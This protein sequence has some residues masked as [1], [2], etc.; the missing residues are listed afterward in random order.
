MADEEECECPECPK[1]LPAYLATF[2]DLM[3]LLM[4]FFV[5]LLAFSEMDVQK[6]KQVAGSMRDAFGVQDKIKMK[7]I[8]KGTSIIAQ[9]FSPGRPQPTPLNEVRQS[10]TETMENTLDVLCNPGRS[11]QREEASEEQSSSTSDHSAEILEKLVAMTQADAVEVASMMKEDIQNGAVEVETRNRRIVIRVKEQGSFPSGSATLHDEFIPIMDKIRSALEQIDGEYSVEGH[12]DDLPISTPRFR[13]N[14]EL[15]SARAVSVA[16]ELMKGETLDRTKFTVVGF[17]DIKPLVEND[18]PENRSK[19]RRVEIV[20]EQGGEDEKYLSGEEPLPEDPEFNIQSLQEAGIDDL[21]GFDLFTGDEAD[22][23]LKNPTDVISVLDE[24][25]PIGADP[26]ANG[27]STQPQPPVNQTESPSPSAFDL[28][29][30][31]FA[32][33]SAD[34]D[35]F[36]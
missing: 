4:C 5:L 34:E 13:S 17:G 6:Y 32:P 36:F 26:Q 2:A 15:A 1:G 27:Q 19:N 28:S 29:T 12:T 33:Q 30:D 24:P 14:W 22:E 11:E 35:E 3:S 25:D 16:H 9:E 31:P 18:T 8:P 7:E 10:T 23:Q 21:E 20:I